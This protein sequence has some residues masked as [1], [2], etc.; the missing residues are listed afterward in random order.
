MCLI[1]EERW[2]TPGETPIL[3]INEFCHQS[4]HLE[5]SAS[6]TTKEQMQQV[7]FSETTTASHCAHA[8]GNRFVDPGPSRGIID[9][10][11]EAKEYSPELLSSMN[12]TPESTVT[13][14]LSNKCSSTLEPHSKEKKEPLSLHNI[15]YFSFPV[16]SMD[17]MSSLQSNNS[18]ASETISTS[19]GNLDQSKNPYAVNIGSQEKWVQGKVRIRGLKLA[20]LRLMQ[21]VLE[22]T[23]L[24]NSKTHD[25]C[26][27]VEGK[28]K[29]LINYSSK[30]S[31]KPATLWRFSGD[32]GQGHL[33]ICVHGLEGN[34]YD[35]RNMRLTIQRRLPTASFLM[36]SSNQHDTHADINVMA[37]NLIDEIKDSLEKM[38]PTHISFI[39]HSLGNIIIRKALSD[40]SFS[41][42]LKA[43]PVHSSTK[44]SY[45]VADVMRSQIL[46]HSFI[47]LSGPH[48]GAVFLSG[49]VNAGLWIMGKWTKST[50]IPQLQ[51]KDTRNPRESLLYS[52]RQGTLLR[53]FRYIVLASSPQDGYVS[54][55]SSLLLPEPRA[56]SRTRSTIFEE[57]RCSLLREIIDSRQ[58]T[59]IRCQVVFPTQ[60]SKLSFMHMAGRAAHV[61]LLDSEEFLSKFFQ[62]HRRCF[63][64]SPRCETF[65]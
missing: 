61:A 6:F 30:F 62:S 42:L 47:S 15:Q 22:S 10:I 37:K 33:F 28:G 36:S 39:G 5:K 1:Q 7:T 13:E 11:T 4:R 38:R 50:S 24:L 12:S 52:M 14:L 31:Q 60:K 23:H 25:T 57:I 16:V 63:V 27:T 49:L 59:L 55:A 43:S 34:Q 2:G 26:E 65:V 21:H 3:F 17:E 46:L 41:D 32:R 19:N 8:Y 51:L 18:N 35:L 20:K 64:R 29:T 45:N 9:L 54:T 58:T 56:G 44:S 53:E 40:S 48:C